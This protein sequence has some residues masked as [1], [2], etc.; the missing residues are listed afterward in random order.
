ME[1]IHLKRISIISTVAVVSALTWWTA[2][3]WLTVPGR[4]SD[5]HTWLLPAVM[6]TALTAVVALSWGLL[7]RPGDR[8]AAILA[9]WAVFVLFWPPNIWYISAL[10]L[11]FLLWYEGSRRIRTDMG[12]RHKVHMWSGLERGVRLILLAMYLMVSLG[13]YLLPTSRAADLKTVS[14]GIRSSLE[15][16][17]GNPTIQSQLDQLPPA[18][19]AQVKRDLLLQVDDAVHRWLGPF[20]PYVPPLLAFALFLTLWGMSFLF[21]EAALLIAFLLFALL[22][23]T[24]FVRIE[25]KS[26]KAETLTL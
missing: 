16:S 8:L 11:F 18:A 21:R 3:A 10:P 25:E 22:K 19:Q 4:F 26:V 13:F 9:S 20:G 24:G 17:Y 6:L 23:A 12:E 7:E 5:W 15:L 2:H 14:S 1:R